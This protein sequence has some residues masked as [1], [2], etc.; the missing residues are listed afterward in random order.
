M[1]LSIHCRTAILPSELFW[2]H[3]IRSLFW[4]ATVAEI[5][6][7]LRQQ[8]LER[9]QSAWASKQCWHWYIFV[10]VDKNHATLLSTQS[11]G[12]QKPFYLPCEKLFPYSVKYIFNMHALPC[13]QALYIQ[14]P[15]SSTK[16]T[17]SVDQRF[18][19]ND[20]F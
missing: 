2:K 8:E 4:L 6:L 10:P 14:S 3:G 13:F 1:R 5:I 16:A 12:D 20:V 17:S 19:M 9:L 15:L 18:V 11:L 7:K